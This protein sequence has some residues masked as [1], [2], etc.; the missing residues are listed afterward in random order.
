MEWGQK[1][2]QQLLQELELELEQQSKQELEAHSE[3]PAQALRP[4]TRPL[5]RLGMVQEIRQLREAPRSILTQALL[6]MLSQS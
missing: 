3:Q 5:S 2:E 6:T 1:S 4:T